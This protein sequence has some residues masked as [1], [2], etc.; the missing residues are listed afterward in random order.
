MMDIS[1][2]EKT[3]LTGIYTDDPWHH[4]SPVITKDDLVKFLE[5]YIDQ[6]IEIAITFKKG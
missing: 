1:V 3:V 2:S 6:P 4:N 5:Q